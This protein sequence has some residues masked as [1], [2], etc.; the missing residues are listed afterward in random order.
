MKYI[1]WLIV[2]LLI[3]GGAILTAEKREITSTPPIVQPDV[4]LSDLEPYLDALAMC[5]SNNRQG[6]RVVDTNGYYSYSAYQFQ[7]STWMAEARAA[8]LFPEAEEEDYVNLIWGRTDQRNVAKVMLEDNPNNWT[9][10]R[11]CS[12]KIGLDDWARSQS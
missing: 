4:V 11:T 3:L 2:S 8:E 12:K 9:H 1:N 5:E 10:W 7:M 6:F